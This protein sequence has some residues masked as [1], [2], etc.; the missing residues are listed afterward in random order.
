MLQAVVQFGSYPELPLKEDF[1]SMHSIPYQINKM[2]GEMYCNFYHHHYDLN[3][4]NCRFFNSYGPG[5]VPGMYRNVISTLFIGLLIIKIF[6]LLAM[7]MKQE[8]LPMY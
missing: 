6:Q 8:I 2:T 1:I 3:I 7:E 5:E 4:V